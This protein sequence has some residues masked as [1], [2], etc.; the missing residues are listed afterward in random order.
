LEKLSR[1]VED[2]VRQARKLETIADGSGLRLSQRTVTSLTGGNQLFDPTEF[3]FLGYKVVLDITTDEA[4]KL[5]HVFHTMISPKEAK[6][7]YSELPAELRE[8]FERRFRLDFDD[9]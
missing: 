7:Q 8:K 9:K 3:D 4:I 2:L 6:R 5:S 1:G